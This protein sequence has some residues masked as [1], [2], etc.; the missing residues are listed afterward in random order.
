MK[1]EADLVGAIFS[2]LRCNGQGFAAIIQDA[3]PRCVQGAEHLQQGAF[4]AAAGA[5]DGHEFSRFDPQINA[6]KRGHL[7]AVVTFLQADR[8]VN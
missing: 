5:D 8:F 6:P 4:T 7:A 2:R 3:L 1:N